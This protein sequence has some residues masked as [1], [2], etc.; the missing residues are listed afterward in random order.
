[1]K[2]KFNYFSHIA[3]FVVGFYLCLALVTTLTAAAKPAHQIDEPYCPTIAYSGTEITAIAVTETASP[4][5][6]PP[7][8]TN[9]PYTPT[10]TP[11]GDS[12][13]RK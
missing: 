10:F 12:S 2:R 4:M 11:V 5:P 7:L 6:N 9:W 1:M 13:R 3:A 8:P